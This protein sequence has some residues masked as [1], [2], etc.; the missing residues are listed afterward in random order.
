[1]ATDLHGNFVSL[2]T[3]WK[4][5]LVFCFDLYSKLFCE[6]FSSLESLM[7]FY[8]TAC[9]TVFTRTDTGRLFCSFNFSTSNQPVFVSPVQDA[10]F[11]LKDF[12][13]NLASYV[14][15]YLPVDPATEGELFYMFCYFFSTAYLINCLSN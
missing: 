13:S 9:L 4:I 3:V 2:F 14:N 1:M 8:H 12:F 6:C 10:L 15:P 7:S 5:T 11:F